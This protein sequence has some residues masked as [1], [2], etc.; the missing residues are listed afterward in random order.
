MKVIV[1]MATIPCRME[2]LKEN[3]PSFK[4]QTYPFDVL[5]INVLSG[6]GS[7]KSL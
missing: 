6:R 2:R 3:I 1:S 7:I 5:V 4:N